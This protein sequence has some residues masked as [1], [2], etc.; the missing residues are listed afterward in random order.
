MITKI[1]DGNEE[2]VSGGSAGGGHV[3]K[4]QSGTDMAQRANLQFIDATLAD[5]STNNK[6]KVEMVKELA[7]A[8]E[9]ASQPD[10]LYLVEDS[11][12]MPGIS[13]NIVSY[14]NTTSGLTADDVQEAVDELASGKI[15][16]SQ[17]SG[18]VKNDGT[19]DT[20]TYAKSST[21]NLTFSVDNDGILNVTYNT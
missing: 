8:S 6:T 5:D 18:L 17:T 13:A 4:N 2:N 12:P 21:S 11:T 16:K 7:N 20:N 10:G 14:S 19:V 3:I 9:L 1:I 15:S